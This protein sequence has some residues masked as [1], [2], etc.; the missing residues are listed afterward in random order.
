MEWAVASEAL[1][2]L[3]FWAALATTWYQLPRVVLAP[4]HAAANGVDGHLLF[5]ILS[6]VIPGGPTNFQS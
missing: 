1:R 3:D 5:L 4:H 6:D 2:D